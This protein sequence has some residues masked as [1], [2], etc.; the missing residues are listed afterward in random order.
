MHQKQALRTRWRPRKTNLW[1]PSE[2][3]HSAR[4]EPFQMIRFSKQIRI[5]HHVG[6]TVMNNIQITE[7]VESV[8][9]LA[10]HQE[11]LVTSSGNQSCAPRTRSGGR[12]DPEA[13]QPPAGIWWSSTWLRF[14]FAKSMWSGAP[15]AINVE[16][17]RHGSHFPLL[18]QC[19]HITSRHV[20]TNAYLTT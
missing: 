10:N 6:V 11:N 2:R 5:W 17:P 18:W 19:W 7:L 14:S 12:L 9:Y 3:K 16:P 20:C 8:T 1:V 4:L 13:T 15:R